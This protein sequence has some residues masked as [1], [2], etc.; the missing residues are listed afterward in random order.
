MAIAYVM[1][2]A[3]YVFP[4]IGGRKVEHLLANVEALEISLSDEQIKY[5]ESVH[6]FNP[7]FPTWMIVRSNSIR[8]LS[9]LLTYSLSS[10]EMALSLVVSLRLQRLSPL[11]RLSNQ[12]LMD[13]M[14]DGDWEQKLEI[15]VKE[16]GDGM[17]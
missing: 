7:G 12:S 1:H 9:F 5:L 2:K 16:L 3:P 8:E 4:I 11:V 6:E 13:R 17:G 15:C 14:F 10:R